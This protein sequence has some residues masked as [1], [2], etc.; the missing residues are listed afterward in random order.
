MN[1]D[2]IPSPLVNSDVSGITR[3]NY[4]FFNYSINYCS[5]LYTFHANCATLVKN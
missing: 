5:M 3:V 2:Q 1:T 4:F